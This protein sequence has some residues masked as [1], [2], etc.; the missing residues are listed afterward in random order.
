M[1]NSGFSFINMRPDP[2]LQARANL[3]LVQILAAGPHDAT[4]FGTIEQVGDYFVAKVS[5]RSR[6]YSRTERAVGFTAD[7]AV[8]RLLNRIEDCLYDWRYS[9]RRGGS[10]PDEFSPE[11]HNRNSDEARDSNPK[12]PIA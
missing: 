6:F 12:K 1:K 4:A 9:R 5:V 10:T 8:E 3:K 2:V 11:P 7:G